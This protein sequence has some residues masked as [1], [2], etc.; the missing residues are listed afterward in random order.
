MKLNE[1]VPEYDILCQMPGTSR[2]E[3]LEQEQP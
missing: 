3:A 1:E 2:A